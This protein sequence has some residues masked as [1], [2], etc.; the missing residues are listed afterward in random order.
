M[1][2]CKDNF[3]IV[4]FSVL[5]ATCVK[6]Y[7]L[8]PPQIARFSSTSSSTSSELEPPSALSI[9]TTLNY[10]AIA[11]HRAQCEEAALPHHFLPAAWTRTWLISHFTDISVRPSAPHRERHG[12]LAVDCHYYPARYCAPSLSLWLRN[13]L[14]LERYL[15]T[16]EGTMHR[17]LAS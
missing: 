16:G 13:K 8:S 9:T 7:P 1:K 5:A 6:H 12:L 15:R 2:K 14:Y 10:T 17:G 3:I 4:H 11:C